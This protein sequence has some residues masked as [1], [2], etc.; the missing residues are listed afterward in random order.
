[1]LIYVD[2]I[3]VALMPGMT[4]RHALIAAL[5]PHFDPGAVSVRDGWGNPVG[6]D[7]ALRDG[8]RLM[9]VVAGRDDDND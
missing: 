6:L 8:D 5:G 2:D 4:V 9:T 7:G 1:M 3:Q